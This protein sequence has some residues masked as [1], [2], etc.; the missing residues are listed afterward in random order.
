MGKRRFAAA[1]VDS[2]LETADWSVLSEIVG[3][4]TSSLEYDATKSNYGL[5]EELFALVETLSW[6]AA[7]VRSGVWTYY[8]VASDHIQQALLTALRRL[9]PADFAETY[10]RGIVVWRS[11]AEIGE[12]DAWIS[13]N[14]T[15]INNWLVDVA[16]AQRAEI[17]NLA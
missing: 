4:V 12:I 3:I 7:S 6:E 1:Y 5:S 17:H 9:A 2:L 10:G 15:R 16:K 13:V 11:E 8:E 14:E